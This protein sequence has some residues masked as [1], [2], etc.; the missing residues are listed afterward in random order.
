M[1]EGLEDNDKVYA[2]AYK[3]T[4]KSFINN[5]MDRNKQGENFP[6]GSIL[7]SNRKQEFT[8]PFS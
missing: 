2:S 1:M 4:N 6:A 3:D 5:R 7:V 8:N